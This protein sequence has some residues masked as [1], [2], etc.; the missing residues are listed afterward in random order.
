MNEED[1][2]IW[3]TIFQKYMIHNKII[4]DMIDQYD[5]MKKEGASHE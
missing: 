1:K 4:A 5:Q 2:E 3:C